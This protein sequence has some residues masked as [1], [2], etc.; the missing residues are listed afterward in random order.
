MDEIDIGVDIEPL[1]L[2]RRRL[3]LGRSRGRR[4]FWQKVLDPA[5]RGVQGQGTAAVDW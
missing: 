2:A 5:V 3:A 4:E 1:W